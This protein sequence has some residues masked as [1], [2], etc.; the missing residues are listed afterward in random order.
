MSANS[1]PVKE[2]GGAY[3]SR[4]ELL[5][6]VNGVLELQLTKLEQVW[7]RRMRAVRGGAQG[8]SSQ[9]AQPRRHAWAVLLTREGACGV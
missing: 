7:P 2:A 1:S 4:T 8:C 3:M 9:T 5:D 6:W